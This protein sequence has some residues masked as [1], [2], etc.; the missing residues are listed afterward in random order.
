VNIDWEDLFDPFH[1]DIQ[2]ETGPDAAIALPAFLTPAFE[3]YQVTVQNVFEAAYSPTMTKFQYEVGVVLAFAA[4]MTAF[5]GTNTPAELAVK[6][7]RAI[8]AAV[9]EAKLNRTLQFDSGGVWAPF[10]Q[11]LIL[12]GP[13]PRR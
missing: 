6:V 13:T 1:W 11:Y 9:N 4:R 10:S 8:R 5:G 7:G 3:I 12:L 2:D